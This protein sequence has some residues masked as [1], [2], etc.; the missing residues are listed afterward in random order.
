MPTS[1]RVWPPVGFALFQQKWARENG[2][3][4]L[5]AQLPGGKERRR[6]KR[7]TVPPVVILSKS[8]SDVPILLEDLSL[9]GFCAVFATHIQPDTLYQVRMVL[10]EGVMETCQARAIWTKANN[11]LP[12]TWTLGFHLSL[13]VATKKQL[14]RFLKALGA[15]CGA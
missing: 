11:T 6:C 15:P 3:R 8:L 12:S 14:G 10:A 7:V 4:P 5:K 1:G 2:V 9:E 13:P